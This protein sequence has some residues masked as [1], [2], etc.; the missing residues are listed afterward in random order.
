M[1]GHALK[2]HSVLFTEVLGSPFLSC[3][4][5]ATRLEDEAITATGSQATRY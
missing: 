3:A 4:T 1:L 5:T 2:K